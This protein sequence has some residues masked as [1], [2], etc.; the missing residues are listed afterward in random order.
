M[1]INKRTIPGN[2]IQ[3]PLAIEALSYSDQSGA[4][5]TV[6]VGQYLQPLGDGA[7]GFTTNATTARI[8]PSAGRNLAVYN[9]DTVVHSV[10]LGTSGSMAALA[11]GA[12]DSNGNVGIAVPPGTYIYIATYLSNW[13]R[14]DSNML[15]V[16]LIGDHTSIK[17][18]SQDNAS[19]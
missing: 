5:K 8:L 16:Y 17:V 10:T 9:S 11:A 19:T 2:Q 14:T 18:Q 15:F 4:Y 13:V 6:P 7:G 1:A 12:T 3:D